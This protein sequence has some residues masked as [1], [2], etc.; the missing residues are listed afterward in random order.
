MKPWLLLP[1]I[2][3]ILPLSAATVTV[4]ASS[5]YTTNFDDFIEG[6]D[7]SAAPGTFT[8]TNANGQSNTSIVQVPGQG[9][10]MRQTSAG[11]VGSVTSNTIATV[12]AT[13][14]T[15]TTGSQFSV[16]TTFVIDSFV[17]SGVANTSLN[18]A[19]NSTF[20]SGYRVVY[21]IS[22]TTP[23]SIGG[24]T[25]AENGTTMTGV[26]TTGSNYTP[27]AGAVLTMTLT[28]FYNSATSVSLAGYLFDSNGTE[29]A[30]VTIT[31]TSA[32]TGNFFGMRTAVNGSG[33]N[34]SVTFTNFTLAV[35]EPASATLALVA[36]GCLSFRRRRA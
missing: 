25:I 13:G 31:D 19:S 24:F 20:G 5:P 8:E 18:A 29:I 7:P 28:G 30:R 17:A 32:Q 23:S 6:D 1:L 16:S 10:G 21:T 36:L 33:A 22:S 14:L 3:S 35:P 11:A 4:T 12:N 15:G 2:G 27:V 34:E 9:L 26:T